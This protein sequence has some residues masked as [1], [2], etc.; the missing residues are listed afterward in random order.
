MPCPLCRKPARKQTRR[1]WARSA[2]NA[3]IAA[4]ME[5]KPREALGLFKAAGRVESAA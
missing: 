2:L 1:A 3:G 5:G 4:L